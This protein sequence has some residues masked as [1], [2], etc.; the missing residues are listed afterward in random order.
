MNEEGTGTAAGV[1]Q[2]PAGGVP[3]EGGTPA[4][5]GTPV[6]DGT[7]AAGGTMAADGTP[8]AGGVPTAGVTP[9]ATGVSA[10]PTQQENERSVPKNPPKQK[11]SA[12]DTITVAAGYKV[13]KEL[14]D[15]IPRDSAEHYN[16]VPLAKKENTLYVGTTTMNNL[17]ARDALNFITTSQGLEYVIQE[18]TAE[19]FENILSQYG[20]AG[21]G[22]NDRGAGGI[23][24]AA[25]CYSRS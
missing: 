21:F 2:N 18:I 16:I 9:A 7:P 12:K 25:R 11:S 24:G 20:E 17:D 3:V 23:G 14:F 1:P 6:A 19:Q 22:L 10:Q 15:F 8:A 4:A 13:M 5:G